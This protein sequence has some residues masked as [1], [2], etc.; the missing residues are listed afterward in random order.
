MA[1]LSKMKEMTMSETQLDPPSPRTARASVNRHSKR[2]PDEQALEVSGS[3]RATDDYVPFP[4]AVVIVCGLMRESQRSR[5]TGLQRRKR[6][7][8]SLPISRTMSWSDR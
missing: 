2:L 5:V 6:A 7:A 8:K 4:K 1:P 3:N